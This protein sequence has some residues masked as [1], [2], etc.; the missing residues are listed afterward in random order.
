MNDRMYATPEG[1]E[2]WK[3]LVF[4]DVRSFGE[5]FTDVRP[6]NYDT[7]NHRNGYP[8]SETPENITREGY[9][10]EVTRFCATRLI[11][12]GRSLLVTPTP[13]LLDALFSDGFAFFDRISFE[14]IYHES[15]DRVLIVANASGIIAS[16]YLAYIDPATV[17]TFG[18]VNPEAANQ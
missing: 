17:P 6:W 12:G 2:L 15:N 13:V 8:Q 16:R 14:A 18:E 4:P 10:R 1:F 3:P 7:M 5:L 9:D 11:P